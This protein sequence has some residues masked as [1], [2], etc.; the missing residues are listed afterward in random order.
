MHSEYENWI[1]EAKVPII[2]INGN[3]D[4]QSI[5]NQL[6][7]ARPLILNEIATHQPLQSISCT[8]RRFNKPLRIS[9]EGNIGSGKS[10]FLNYAKEND[11]DFEVCDVSIRV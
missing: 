6:D 11:S 3:G 5:Q 1:Q 10:T 8:D 9:I 2:T 7:D 4:L